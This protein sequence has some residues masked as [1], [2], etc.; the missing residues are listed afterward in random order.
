MSLKQ[1]LSAGVLALALTCLFIPRAALAQFDAATVLGTVADA[2][3]AVVPGATVTLTNVETGITATTAIDRAGNFQF[4]NVRVGTYSLRG[5]LQGFSAAIAANFAVTVNAR[6]RV[7]L[8]WKVG[9]LGET[10]QVTGAARLLESESS[11]RGQ[12]IGR[13]QIVNLPLNG[14][15]YADLALLSPGVRKSSIA[16]SRDAS[17]NVNGLRSSLN[18][19][20]LDG[21]MQQFLRHEQPGLF[22]SGSCGDARRR[23]RIQGADQQLRRR[24]R[25]AP[26]RRDQRDVPERHG[27]S[28]AAP[29]GSSTATRR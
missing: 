4:L 28:S 11:D 9:G 22:E 23:R 6:Q 12:V 18:N 19:F 25:P 2:T 8:I 5:E 10:V 24:V 14:R 7:D 13:E 26:A 29:R 1:R 21:V 27:L 3:G 20:I 15:A 16:D 17:F